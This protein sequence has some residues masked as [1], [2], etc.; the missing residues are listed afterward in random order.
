MLHERRLPQPE[1]DDLDCVYQV[2]LNLLDWLLRTPPAQLADRTPLVQQF[3]QPVA[4]WMWKRIRKPAT[5]TQFGLAVMALAGRALAAPAEA[6]AVAASI[7]QDAQFHTRWNA[8]GYELQFPRLHAGWLDPVRAVAE[9]F[10]DWLAGSG[11]DR[12]TFGL[13]GNSMTRTRIMAAFRPQSLGVCGYCDGP[14][15]EVGTD[16]EANDCDHFFPKSQWPHLA[17]HPANLYS[18]CKGCNST[19][20]LARKPMG[21]ADVLGL[22]ETYH[23]MLR[24]GA[25]SISVI[26]I[27]TPLSAR[28]VAITIRDTQFPRRAETLNDT[29]DLEVRWASF[30]NE[31]LDECVSTFV[32]KAAKD[33]GRGWAVT[34]DSVRE[35]IE[36]DIAWQRARRGKDERTIRQVA[37]LEYQLTQHLPEIVA[38]LS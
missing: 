24:P 23:P 13:T 5:R 16:T 3:G 17:I 2:M 21:E 8:V 12:A 27:Q 7:T 25:S 37:A 18:A 10:Y 4:G 31:K 36:N 35:L 9:P 19:W 22:S 34:P 26:A 30:V 33:K 11:F 14:L 32:A 28:R 38:D 15:G 20:K 29:L 6:T 1:V